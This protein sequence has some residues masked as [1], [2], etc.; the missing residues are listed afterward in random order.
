MH[1]LI[2]SMNQIVDH[3]WF[4]LI[5]FTCVTLAVILWN[6][7]PG[8]SWALLFIALVFI[9]LR[10]VTG[11]SSL[12][13]TP[14]D[15]P[16]AIFLITAGIGIWAAYQPAIALIKF[17]LILSA[18][19]LFLLL[20]QLPKHYLW[21]VAGILSLLGIGIGIFFFLS[22][23]WDVQAQKFQLLSQIGSAWMRI[24]PNL[25]L[26]VIHP[27]DVAGISGLTLPFSIALTLDFSRKK[28]VPGTLSFGLGSVL[29]LAAILLS[30]SRG[31][32]MA[33]GITTGLWIMWEITGRLTQ[34]RKPAHQVFFVVLLAL[35]AC[36]A[37]GNIW[38][39][40]HGK[41]SEISIGRV[42][43]TV[44]DQRYHVFW[45]DIELIKDVPFT[46][47]GLDSFPGLY[48]H[49]ILVNPNYILGYGHNIFLDAALQQGIV[50]GLM[51]F[52]IYMGSIWLL[53][54]QP[55]PPGSSIL[56]KAIVSSLTIIIF[57]GLVDNIVY[58]TF[59][60]H[61][62][63]I[64]PGMAAG[65]MITK[66]TNNAETR[67][68]QSQFR[69]L[70]VPFVITF[71]LL[72]IGLIAFRRPLLSAWYTNLGAVEM[73]KVELSDFP[74]SSWDEGRRVDL[75][76]PAESFFTRAVN[77]EPDN[78][79]ANY[80]LGLIAMAKRD[81]PI[82]I[83]HLEIARINDPYH[84]GILK[85][86]GLSYIWNGQI[87]DA[88]PLLSLIPEANQELSIYPWW[89]RELDRPDLATYA[90]QYLKLVE[91][92]Q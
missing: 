55:A 8:L 58:R 9:L 38:S 13:R 59:Y 1:L 17:W 47:A 85:A 75:L 67:L 91:S 71:S 51:L 19:L 62:L 72:I 41:L 45:S 53:I 4:L 64:V 31:S 89:W 52:I 42:G 43:A 15:I 74:T 36:M 26:A 69:R 79:G 6:N 84:R 32:W 24:R 48:S 78:P 44:S 22:N 77:N 83:S 82:A 18:G 14:F 20:T 70:L 12:V 66:K 27:N 23:N 87:D 5:E 88:V 80:H 86:L 68:G 37:V 56:R 25:R 16:I 50:G 81:Y 39:S 63:F 49:Y 90:E 28:S 7:L 76:S 60:T 3:T 57:H 46:G 35:L 30:A 34:Q 61:L 92:G 29:I 11:K 40:L 21:W 10:L 73:A 65:L 2:T 33:I 54:F